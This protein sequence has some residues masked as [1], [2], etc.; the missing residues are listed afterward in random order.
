MANND[1]DLLGKAEVLGQ[2]IPNIE[3]GFKGK[4]KSMLAKDIAN[5]HGKEL[6]KVNEIINNNLNRFKVGVDII[7]LKTNDNFLILL[8]DNEI[9]SQ[10]SINRSNNVYLLSERGYAKLIKMFND[11]LSWE[12]YDKLL[13]EYFEMRKFLTEKEMIRQVG[14]EVRKS[15]TDAIKESGENKRMKGFAYS[16]YT[17]MIYKLVLGMT[18]KKYKEQHNIEGNLRDSLSSEQLK[19]I[20]SLEG[21]AKHNLNL[22]LEYKEIKEVIQ[23]A[24]VMRMDRLED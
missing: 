7:D 17:N 15:M 20:E 14:I 22:G 23:N 4:G 12:L 13:D 19:L 3:G 21:L 11:D 6:F 9:L 5:F 1:I 2:E 24:Y 18:A 10:N 16:T 8:K